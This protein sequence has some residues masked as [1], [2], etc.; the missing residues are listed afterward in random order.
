MQINIAV[1]FV[2]KSDLKEIVMN[3]PII[4]A[5]DENYAVPTGVLIT[6]IM[7]NAEINDKYDIYIMIPKTF[8][9]EAYG[10]VKELENKYNNLAIELVDMG[11]YFSNVNT[12]IPHITVP[13]YY[14]LMAAELLPTVDKCIYLDSDIIVDRNLASLYEIELDG[15]Y[16]A[17]AKA[18]AWHLPEKNNYSEV[19]EFGL[20]DSSKYINAGAILLNLKKIREDNMTEVLLSHVDKNYPCQDQD[21]L[22]LLFY[23]NIKII[24]LKYNFMVP[25]IVGNAFSLEQKLRVYSAE[26]ILDAKTNPCVIHYCTEEKPWNDLSSPFSDKWW[27]YAYKSTYAIDASMLYIGKN[28]LDTRRKGRNFEREKK[29]LQKEISDLKKSYSYRIG[30]AITFLPR[31]MKKTASYYKKNGMKKTLNK[32]KSKLRK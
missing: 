15:Y 3:I 23:P 11:D 31:M 17:G 30:R 14:R 19:R 8:S 6:S 20:Y 26:E 25:R 24:P 13:T 1:Y 5:T 27:N 7:E 21:I 32:I 12:T 2:F 22:N 29:E 18:L 9:E 4:L 28:L 16:M 10:K